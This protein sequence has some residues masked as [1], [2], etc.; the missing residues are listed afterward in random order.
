LLHHAS[1]LRNALCTDLFQVLTKLTSAQSYIEAFSG[2]LLEEVVVSLRFNVIH[3]SHLGFYCSLSFSFLKYDVLQEQ[4]EAEME[5]EVLQNENH[6]ED[7]FRDSK[8][9]TQLNSSA[10]DRMSLSSLSCRI[11]FSSIYASFFRSDEG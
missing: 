11:C 2:K 4:E 7:Q 5:L 3:G 9:S 1:P 8:E 10:G 6:A